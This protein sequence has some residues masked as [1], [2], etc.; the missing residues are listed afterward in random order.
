MRKNLPSDQDDDLVRRM[1]S[2]DV[3]ALD[4]FY[5]RYN[6]LA[7]SLV[8]RIV[9]N[10][11]DAENV[12]VDVFS[13]AWR[14]SPNYDAAL[15]KPLSWLLSI[16]RTCAINVRNSAPTQAVPEPTEW[17]H[18]DLA[19]TVQEALQQLPE[20]Q[21]IPMEMAYFQALNHVQIAALLKEPAETVKEQIRTGMIYLREKLKAYL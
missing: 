17:N 3:T 8:F 13:Q 15:G 21:R 19:R 12:L 6:Q 5:G 20:E 9:G 7:F 4:T 1:A 2:K 10:R 14:E 11:S 18:S 16:A